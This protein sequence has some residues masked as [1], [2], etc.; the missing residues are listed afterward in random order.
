[1]SDGR[2]CAVMK[3]APT[4][5]FRAHEQIGDIRSHSPNK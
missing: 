3:N 2:L 4:R 5:L 1:M